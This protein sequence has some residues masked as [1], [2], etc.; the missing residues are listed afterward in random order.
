MRDRRRAAAGA[1]GITA[2]AVETADMEE[3]VA[4]GAAVD[5]ML[6]NYDPP[7]GSPPFREAFAGF[8][9]QECGWNVTHE[10]IAVLP[11]SQTAF[12]CFSTC[13]PG[14]RG[15]QASDSVSVGARMLAMPTR[16][17]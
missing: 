8:L 3:M 5:R 13:W 4:D 15:R 10:N 7:T 16:A 12:S 9:K 6:L 11:S 1:I 17:V 14:T 2:G